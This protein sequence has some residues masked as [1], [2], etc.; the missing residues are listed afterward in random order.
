MSSINKTAALLSLIQVIQ[1]GVKRHF[2]A[3]RFSEPAIKGSGLEAG[4]NVTVLGLSYRV[5][6]TRL[7][8]EADYAR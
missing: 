1:V 4:F 5:T 3:A 8:E 7:D 6:I 2:R